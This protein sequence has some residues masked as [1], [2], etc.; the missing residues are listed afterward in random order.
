MND[1]CYLE[2]IQELLPRHSDSGGD[3]GNS[4]GY[5]ESSTSDLSDTDS[6]SDSQKVHSSRRRRRGKGRL[7]GDHRVSNSTSDSLLSSN[8]FWMYV[9]RPVVKYVNRHFR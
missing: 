3:V 2:L 4:S 7:R 9:P 6:S 5:Q 8:E 1:E